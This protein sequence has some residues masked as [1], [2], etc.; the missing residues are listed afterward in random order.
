MLLVG[1]SAKESRY[2]SLCREWTLSKSPDVRRLLKVLS[3]RS[4]SCDLCAEKRKKQLIALAK[5]GEPNRFLTLTVS[6]AAG[7][8]PEDAYAVLMRAWHLII[9]RLRRDPRFEAI[10]YL[11]VVEATKAGQPH[12]HILLRSPFLSQSLISEWMSELASSPI[13][14]IESI[15]TLKQVANYV[16]KYVAKAPARFG[17]SKRY[18]ASRDYELDKS[19]K[20]VKS[21]NPLE[22]WSIDRRHISQIIRDLTLDG[23]IEVESTGSVFEFIPPARPPP[24]ISVPK[25]AQLGFFRAH[26]R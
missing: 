3:C 9:K 25:E 2:V 15:K 16:A 5:S 17:S 4:W 10:E 26:K 6:P 20:P 12:L 23:W 22:N 18:F 7:D 1:L 21:L 24:I 14:Y 13:V 19:A 11:W 8:T